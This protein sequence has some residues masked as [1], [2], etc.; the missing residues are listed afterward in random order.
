[1]RSS[2]SSGDDG[3]LVLASAAA[4]WLSPAPESALLASAR[5]GARGAR[6]SGLLLRWRAR[7]VGAEAAWRRH[8]ASRAGA[9][10]SRAGVLPRARAAARPRNHQ[11]LHAPR[12]SGAEEARDAVRKKWLAKGPSAL[13]Q[14]PWVQPAGG[15]VNRF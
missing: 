13:S 3:A 15:A 8:A 14:L 5:G 6:L 12:R 11:L 9:A 1:V 10:I 7:L 2:S 4:V